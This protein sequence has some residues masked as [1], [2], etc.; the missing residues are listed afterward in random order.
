[1]YLVYTSVKKSAMNTEEMV[2]SYQS[3]GFS[4]KGISDHQK[5]QVK[6]HVFLCFL[7]DYLEWH[8]RQVWVLLLYMDGD[9]EATPK[10]KESIR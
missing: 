6:E 2:T 5:S 10:K 7:V 9:K 4:R 1:M 3:T 8:F